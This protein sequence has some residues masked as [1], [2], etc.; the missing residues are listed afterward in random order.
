[1][2]TQNISQI[3]APRVPLVD[4]QMNTVSREWFMWFNNL[5][6][7][8]GTG[9]GIT[10]VINGGTGLGIIPTNGQLLIGNGTGYA[11]GTLTAGNGISV[12]NGAG[13]ITVVNSLPDR[14]V[15][16]T[17]AGAT[18][19]TGTYPNFTISSTV[20]VTS[21][22]A[23]VPS[24]LSISGSPI[25]SSGT[26]AISYS[27]TPLPV[28]N[29][30]TGTATPALVAGTNVTITG[31][32]PNQTI[33]ASGGGGGS[34]TVTSVAALTL[35]TTGTDLS[36]TVATGTTTPVI[37]LN[38]PTASATNR[39]ALS[40]ADWT[41][42][43]NKGSGTVT[44]VAT[45]GTVNGLTLTGGPITSSGTVTLGG[46]LDLSSPPAIGGTTAAAGSFTTLIGGAGSANYEQ[47]TGGSA[48]NAV[49]F[50][51]LGT[52]SNISIT[53]QPKNTGAIDL[54]AGSK[55]VNISNGGT[56]TAITGT[57]SGSYTT[58]PTFTISAPT[59]AGGTTATGT[60]AMA[61]LTITLQ[62]GGSGYVI[63][64]TITLTGGTFSQAITLIVAT[65]SGSAVATFTTT[66]G[67][68]YTVLPTNP[69]SQGS[70]S[71]SGTGATFN[72]TAWQVRL[73]A[74]TITAAGSGYVEQPTIT[75]SSGSAAAYATVGS[76]SSIKFIGGSLDFVTPSGT[77][78]NITDGSLSTGGYV[79]F[80][81]NSST[82]AI[83]RASGSG[84][85][86][87]ISW[88]SK[89]SGSHN[90]ATNNAAGTQQMV[91][92]HTASAVN[93]VQ[94]TGATTASKVVAISAQGSDTD[95]TLSLSPKGAGTIRFG[96]YTASA[97]LAVAGYI[98]I[99]DSGGTTRRLL[100]G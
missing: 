13:S 51:T 20:G 72:V 5:Y 53:L 91:I 84:G 63:G 15:S 87:G 3:P 14:V 90:F 64:D 65:L 68:T 67:G 59:T 27:A 76:A 75:F 80:T 81:N 58:V 10:P 97:L 85:N 83:N 49:Q 92:S 26:L 16:L 8:T 61:A 35:G 31:T 96:T 41:A 60:C 7:I 40:A 50:Q 99:T 52:D 39:G 45:A 1:M 69:I 82:N 32:W 19:V 42:F 9:T 29:G 30:G 66:N 78:L 93:Y 25:T 33:N 36:S 44:S 62:A 89:G 54:A 55:G 57:A 47:I 6:A 24:F 70:T 12:T 74:F 4:V 94:M 86:I 43:N 11:L 77:A 38:V 56:V 79:S 22:A 95:V 28:A 37:T 98:T 46:T 23:T 18:T 21:V 71:G 73:T 100:V 17:G 88:L 2:A 34:G 48:G